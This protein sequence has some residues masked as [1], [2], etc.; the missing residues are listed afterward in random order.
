MRTLI[1]SPEDAYRKSDLVREFH[2]A[3]YAIFVEALKR[4]DLTSTARMEYDLWDTPAFRAIRFLTVDDQDRPIGVARMICS[5]ERTMFEEN[6]PNYLWSP[7]EKRL[8]L[9]EI[10][11]V[12][13]RLDLG[14]DDRERAIL[15]LLISMEEWGLQNG[16]REVMLLTFKKIYE[17]RLSEMTPIGPVKSLW[18]QDYIALTG[19]ITIETLND[20]RSQ[21]AH[22]ESRMANQDVA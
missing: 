2:L 7:H 8:D 22:V 16:V 11:R 6:F 17:K 3:R 19:E 20:L 21:L 18:G 5:I 15:S 14:R 9:W 10:Q 13:I 12:G 4:H 1:I